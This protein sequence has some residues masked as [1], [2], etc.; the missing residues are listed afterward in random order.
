MSP[1]T[2]SLSLFAP[3]LRRSKKYKKLET[4]E[5]EKKKQEEAND[6]LTRINFKIDKLLNSMTK[7]EPDTC[8]RGEEQCVTCRVSRAVMLVHPCQ[9][10][11]LCRLCFVKMIKHA[12]SSRQLPLCCVVCNGKIQR[13]KNNNSSQQLELAPGLARERLP[14]SVSGYSLAKSVSNYSIK[15]AASGS[16]RVSGRSVRSSGSLQSLA[17]IR[18]AGSASSWFSVNSLSSFQCANLDRN[19]NTK[20]RPHSL[21]GGPGPAPRHRLSVSSSS[22][23]ARSGIRQSS[24]YHGISAVANKAAPPPSSQSVDNFRQLPP[25]ISPEVLSP[26][27]PPPQWPAATKKDVL[28]LKRRVKSPEVHETTFTMSTIEEEIESVNHGG[29]PT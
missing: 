8:V 16:S 19:H 7:E 24:S 29:Y 22:G 23:S 9:H 14:S 27:S 2:F 15:S 12:V 28:Q 13:V 1:S 17:S 6:E 20:L 5:P 3:F 4:E 18:S 21:V 26:T 25:P 10:T 11:A